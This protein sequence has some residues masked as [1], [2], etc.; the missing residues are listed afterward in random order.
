MTT[1]LEL[2]PSLYFAKTFKI[3]QDF[4][5]FLSFNVKIAPFQGV[6]YTVFKP[7]IRPLEPDPVCTGVGMEQIILFKSSVTGFLFLIYRMKKVKIHE[8]YYFYRF[9]VMWLFSYR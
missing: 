8:K 9:I 1:L 6:A 2:S 7:E 4:I 3:K 5:E